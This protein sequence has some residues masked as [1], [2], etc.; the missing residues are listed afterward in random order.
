MSFTVL[1]L[2][3]TYVRSCSYISSPLEL[4]NTRPLE[5]C[6]IIFILVHV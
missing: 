4:D 1:K 6:G 5:Y 2:Q 3:I